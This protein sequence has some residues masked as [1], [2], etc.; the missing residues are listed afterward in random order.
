[1]KAAAPLSYMYLPSH[2]PTEWFGETSGLGFAGFTANAPREVGYPHY[3]GGGRPRSGRANRDQPRT[4]VKG[5][6]SE[7]R[8]GDVVTS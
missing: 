8:R 3:T 1:M 4:A 5:R 6:F 2:L 7:P